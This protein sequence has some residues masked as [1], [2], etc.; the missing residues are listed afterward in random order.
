MKRL[1]VFVAPAVFGLTA[2]VVEPVRSE[3]PAY[4]PP[5]PPR[6]VPPP[7]PQYLPPPPPP[8]YAPPP[9]P[10]AYYAPP[11]DNSAPPDTYA[12]PPDSGAYAQDPAYAPT[13]GQTEEDYVPPPPPPVVSV[14]VDPPM[15]EPEPI[16]VPWA[17]P[18]MLVED[19][20]PM[21][22]YGAYWTGG[23]WVWQGEWVWAHGRW[24]APPYAGYGWTQPYYENRGGI[25]IFVPG[26]WRAPGAVFI[27]PAPTLTVVVVDARPGAVRGPRCEGPEGVFVPPPPGSRLGIIVPAPV[28]TAPA[29][30]VGAP[31]V[32]HHGMHIRGDDEG[33]VRIE[34]PAGVTANGLAL[35]FTAPRLAHLAAA[36]APVVRVAAP[37]PASKTP[38]RS[39]SPSQGYARLPEARPVQPVIARPAMVR[40]PPIQDGRRSDPGQRFDSQQ[41]P[42]APSAQPP[43][44]PVPP[45]YGQRAEPNL[46]P[47]QRPEFNPPPARRPEFNQQPAQRPEFNQQPVQRPEFNQR[48]A[49][50]N[51]PENF[52]RPPPDLQREPARPREAPA[53]RPAQPFAQP[54]RA[55][56]PPMPRIEEPRVPHPAAPAPAAV[57]RPV[58]PPEPA[59]PPAPKPRNEHEE[60]E[61][62]G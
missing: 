37:P 28:G 16:G 32:I 19:P 12:P 29:V 27:A 20:G 40:R 1:F 44:S 39:F 8:A 45:P 11:P 36:Q 51:R 23:Y 43:R 26:Y 47:A 56:P 17:P 42:A 6:Y 18:P 15:E 41:R 61:R 13:D 59:A 33:H 9:P 30:V 10:D 35:N 46:P 60:R 4:I 52:N 53:E 62:R 22:F 34:A 31:P 38:I 5:P 24:L 57:P 55:A 14:F 50:P 54:P 2:C 49:A 21:P 48:P 58:P 7:P 25:V 3:P